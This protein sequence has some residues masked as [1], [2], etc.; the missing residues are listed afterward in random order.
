MISTKFRFIKYHIEIVHIKKLK[1]LWVLFIRICL[2]QKNTEKIITL[3]NQALKM[4][5]SKLNKKIIH[6]GGIIVSFETNGRIMNYSSELGFSDIKYPFAF[7][8]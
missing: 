7:V 5:C 2:N 3:E 1:Y 4:F 6:A 8:E